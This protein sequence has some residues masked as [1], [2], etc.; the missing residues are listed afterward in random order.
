MLNRLKRDNLEARKNKDKF[1][2]G[3]L[4]CLI[5]DIEMVGKNDGNRK[6]T[7]PEAIKVIE[8]FHKITKSNIELAP[9]NDEFKRELEIYEKYLPK[10]M[11]E[12]ELRK[13]IKDII[14]ANEFNSM[15]DIG[16]VMG[17]LNTNFYGEYDGKMAS[18]IVR[19]LLK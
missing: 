10:K 16:K 11:S 7:T 17:L 13:E 5:G 1:T 18:T 12:D 19:E 9:D 3:I 4:T 2:A 15:K 8:K 14:E 6:T